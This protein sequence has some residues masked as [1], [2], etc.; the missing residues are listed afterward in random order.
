MKEQIDL[1]RTGTAFLVK[2]TM[3]TQRGYECDYKFTKVENF[4]NFVKDPYEAAQALRRAVYRKL[5]F[6]EKLYKIEITGLD[7]ELLH[8]EEVVF[9]PNLPKEAR[10]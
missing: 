10:G 2:L 6:Y 5:R 1:S 7:Y 3:Q 4:V 9:L 8:R